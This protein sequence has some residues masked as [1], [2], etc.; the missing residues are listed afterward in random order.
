[1]E[2]IDLYHTGYLVLKQPDVHYGRKNADFGQG[3]YLTAQRDF[4]VRWSR[5]RK[6]ETTY[7]NHY[8]LTLDGLRVKKLQRDREWFEYLQSNRAWREDQWSD[9]DLIIGPIAND[10]IY[11]TLGI[12]TSGILRPEQSLAILS[13][14]PVYEQWAIKT[15]RAAAQLEWLEAEQL[16]HDT[17][18]AS[19]AAVRAEEAEYQRLV[20][21]LVLREDSGF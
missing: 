9:C 13:V 21:E 11:D 5:E 10:I 3:F 12:T 20:S 6:G 4:A 8:S 15:E 2:R 18:T 16:D 19:R 17:L 7:I 1:M 14:G